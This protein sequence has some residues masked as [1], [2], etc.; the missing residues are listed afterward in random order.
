MPD[1]IA[2]L[3]DWIVVYPVRIVVL[4]D[5]GVL[6]PERMATLRT[7]LAILADGNAAMSVWQASTPRHSRAGCGGIDRFWGG[8][9]GQDATGLCRGGARGSTPATSRAMNSVPRS[10]SYGVGSKPPVVKSGVG[11][12]AGWAPSRLGKEAF[13]DLGHLSLH[14]RA[15][16]SAPSQQ[17]SRTCDILDY[18][19]FFP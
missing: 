4:P 6:Y 16:I 8:S 5:R 19:M 10:P 18:V 12:Q 11:G 2:V 15:F 7:G 1:R 3:P 9:P 17:I 13:D 14:G